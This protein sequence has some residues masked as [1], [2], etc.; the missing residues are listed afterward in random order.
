MAEQSKRSRGVK[1]AAWIQVVP[2][3]SGESPRLGVMV[4]GQ[5]L[6]HKADGQE[7][8]QD[9][10]RALAATIEAEGSE[11]L[12]VIELP[13]PPEPPAEEGEAEA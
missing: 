2:N 13:A 3:I 6:T 1:P 10:L 11:Y 8:T 9:E 5:P 4:A 12:D 7:L